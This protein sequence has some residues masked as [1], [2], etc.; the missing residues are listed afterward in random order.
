M[1]WLREY[2][3]PLA[4]TLVLH[5]VLLIWLTSD[6]AGK[7][8]QFEIKEPK[9]IKASLVKLKPQKKEVVKKPPQKPKVKPKK[10]EPKVKPKVKPKV[11]KPD[12]GIAQQKKAAEAKRLKQIEA[13]RLKKEQIEK[14]RLKQEQLEK[15]QQEEQQR[16]EDDLLSNLEDEELVEDAAEDELTAQSYISF[17]QRAVQSKWNRP[18][19]ARNGMQ[20]LLNIQLIPTGDVVSVTVAKSSGNDAFDRSAV[21]AVEKAESFPELTELESRIFEQYYRRFTLLFKPED[22]R[23]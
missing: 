7:S 12:P 13:D 16:R 19:S 6:F 8:K 2:S 3:I 11:V 23:L 9:F 17:I 21:A 14:E 10:T 1:L 22:L 15:L 20:V 4:T 18:P 5:L